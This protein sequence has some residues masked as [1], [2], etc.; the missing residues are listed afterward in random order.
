VAGVMIITGS[1]GESHPI[2]ATEVISSEA[3]F[4]RRQHSSVL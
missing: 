1:S 4:Q 3:G 2:L